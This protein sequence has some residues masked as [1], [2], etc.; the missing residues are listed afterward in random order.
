M[1]EFKIMDIRRVLHLSLWEIRRKILKLRGLIRSI[2]FI[3]EF[4]KKLSTLVNLIFLLYLT[5]NLGYETHLMEL[6][7]NYG[8]V[9]EY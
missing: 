1:N 2:G 3:I 5:T 6:W 9:G 4:I 8:K 7:M